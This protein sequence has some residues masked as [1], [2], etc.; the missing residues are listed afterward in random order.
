MFDTPPPNN[1]PLEPKAPENKDLP[2]QQPASTEAGINISGKKEPEDI[3]ADVD[4]SAGTTQQPQTPAPVQPMSPSGGF[5]WKVVLG[6]GI[7]LLVIALGVGGWYIFKSFESASGIDQ[8]IAIDSQPTSI[9]AT[10]EP[11]NEAVEKD[12][13]P[14]PSDDGMA[15][16]QATLSLLQSQAEK[17]QQDLD[18]ITDSLPQD[19]STSTDNELAT[20]TEITPQQ[21]VEPPVTAPQNSLG[22][23][24][25]G[26]DSDEDGLTNSEESL[27]GTDPNSL[28]S[29]GD[30][31][32]DMS[33]INNGY[34]PASK[35]T[36]L[37]DSSHLDKLSIG[38][39]NTIMPVSWSKKPGISGSVV[40]ETGT[41][42]SITINN[43]PYSESKP[44]ID[45][46]ITKYPGTTS[47]DFEM[48]ANK[49]GADVVYSKDKATAWLLKGNTIYTFRYATNGSSTL[50]FQKIFTIMVEN[51]K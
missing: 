24:V 39:L 26:L 49:S 18:S 22:P 51:A 27:L 15:A 31:Y 44:L 28:D 43:D 30:G 45:W 5:P 6:I 46:L 36:M 20:T 32:D 37:Q 40:I 23:L 21:T 34:D 17:E 2:P 11:V 42:A 38:A 19:T 33:E 7:P 14:E 35:G 29:D 16:S 4:P 41:P 1:L 48:G 10:S 12:M 50:D 3:F 25:M 47:A 9:P 13:I 8:P